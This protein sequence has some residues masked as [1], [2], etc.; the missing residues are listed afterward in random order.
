MK[1]NFFEEFDNY[2]FIDEN[3]NKLVI[4]VDKSL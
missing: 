4:K 2:E 1:I 3:D